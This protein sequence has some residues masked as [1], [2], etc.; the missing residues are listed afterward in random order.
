M[1]GCC[2]ARVLLISSLLLCACHGNPVTSTGGS[3]GPRLKVDAVR[4]HRSVCYGTCPAYE[5]E[6]R[7]DGSVRFKGE[8]FVAVKGTR[9][10]SVTSQE[11]DAVALAVERANFFDLESSYRYKTDGC[12]EWWTD[13]PTVDIVVT[14]A[15]VTKHVEYYYGCRGIK[16]AEDIDALSKVIDKAAKTAQ[17]IGH[18]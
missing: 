14:R 9:T 12:K 5:V 7:S 6:L 17:W 11:M 16:V 1:S 15:G 8:D 4:M 3:D 2:S 13:N 18:E 10:A